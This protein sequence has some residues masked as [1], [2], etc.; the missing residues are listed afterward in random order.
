MKQLQI[1]IIAFFITINVSLAQCPQGYALSENLIENGD[2]S[3]GNFGFASQYMSNV[4]MILEG[5]YFVDSDARKAFRDFKGS[6]RNGASDKFLIVNGATLR[7]RILWGQ[8]IEVLPNTEYT[9]EMWLT[10]LVNLNVSRL[11]VYINGEPFRSSAEPYAEVGKWKKYTA[12]WNS[13]KLNHIYLEIECLSTKKMGNDFGI[14]DLSFRACL[15]IGKKHLAQ[16]GTVTASLC[17]REY[18]LGKELLKNGSFE[19]GTF[20]FTTDYAWRYSLKEP[21]TFQVSNFTES[22]NAGFKGRGHTNSYDNFMIL[23]GSI[24]KNELVWSQKVTV[25]ANQTHTFSGWLSALSDDSS[26]TLEARVDGKR[27]GN[28][29]INKKLYQ[30]IPFNFKWESKAGKM[31]EVN[32]YSMSSEKFGND[33]GIDDLS[34][35]ACVPKQKEV[36]VQQVQEKTKEIEE[37]TIAEEV[38]VEEKVEENQFEKAILK[39]ETLVL[40]NVQF[41]QGEYTLLEKGK[42]ELDQLVKALQQMPTI[43]IVLNGHTDNRGD[44]N[45]NLRLSQRRVIVCKNYLINKGIT[46]DRIETKAYGQTKPIADNTTDEGRK[47]NRRVEVE[48]L[49]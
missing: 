5:A 46:E 39:H 38:L 12:K 40:N 11:R 30:W 17:G 28:I 8:R 36:I 20:G 27:I 15:P 13:G 18:A 24:K 6:G 22:L 2:F 23:N 3:S 42:Q 21:G 43:N 26:V 47:L 32:L 35:R 10:N 31:V 25:E 16:R 1:F 37:P 19:R 41:E 33:F 34:F 7:N 9:F 49:N 45:K 4:D 48:F 44:A 29:T 14:D